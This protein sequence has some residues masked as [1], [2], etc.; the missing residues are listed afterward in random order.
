MPRPRSERLPARSP[1]GPLESGVPGGTSGSGLTEARAPGPFKGTVALKQKD[2]RK[3]V[4]D[5]DQGINL[6]R[7]VVGSSSENSH[8]HPRNR[9]R[10]RIGREWHEGGF[11]KRW[12]GWN[13]DAFGTSGIQLNLIDEIFEISRPSVR[14]SWRRS[15]PSPLLLRPLS[16]PGGGDA[17]GPLA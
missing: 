10:V 7:I 11:S 6:K 14:K 9:Y 2:K 4:V 16:K 5:P 1:V 15:V 17:S 3:G 12:F 8:I 13:F